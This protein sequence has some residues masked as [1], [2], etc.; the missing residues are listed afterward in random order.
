LCNPNTKRILGSL[1]Y[2]ISGSSA[3]ANAAL[4]A[5]ANAIYDDDFR[6][7]HRPAIIREI[8]IIAASTT[9]RWR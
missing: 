6:I 4:V 2:G 1:Q 8:V 3:A 7:L 5:V 9:R